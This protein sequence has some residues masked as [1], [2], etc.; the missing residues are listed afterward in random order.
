MLDRVTITG[1]DDKVDE[2]ILY[3]ISR[4]YPF[5]EW[6]ILFSPKKMGVQRFPSWAWVQ[7]L[8][9]FNCEKNLQ[10]LPPMQLSAHIC[11][12]WVRDIVNGNWSIKDE[13]PTLFSTTDYG[14]LPAFHRMQLNFS[15]YVRRIEI[16]KF[17][18]ALLE[19][20]PPQV[21]YQMKGFYHERIDSPV[22]RML[23]KD[24]EALRWAVYMK[25]LGDICSAEDIDQAAQWFMDH[26]NEERYRYQYVEGNDEDS[27]YKKLS[28]EEYRRI[29][30]ALSE[31]EKEEE[32][33][34]STNSAMER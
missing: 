11:G 21:I 20:Q 23:L 24:L 6:G 30:L 5:V 31:K 16:G 12:K 18:V 34:S 14:R 25:T 27:S 17:L 33:K 29:Y 9:A 15:P 7:N 10:D 13:V 8:L 4:Q 26:H 2:D 22:I 19:A 1:A 3:E 28:W 32:Y